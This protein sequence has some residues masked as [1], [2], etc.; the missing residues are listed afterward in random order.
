MAGAIG[1]TVGVTLALKSP[2]VIELP[3]TVNAFVSTAAGWLVML[4]FAP[5][6]LMRQEAEKNREMLRLAARV[7]RLATHGRRQDE[8]LNEIVLER[9]D[10]IGLLSRSIRSAIIAAEADRRHSDRLRRTMSHEIERETRRA[11]KRL[12]YEAETDPLTGLGNRRRLEEVLADWH[13]RENRRA[14]PVLAAVAIDMDHFKAVNDTLGHDVGD[15]CLQ[16]L[17]GVLRSTVREDDCPVRLGGDE[18]IVLM[19]NRDAGDAAAVAKRIA[20]LFGQM[21]WTSDRVPRPTL[22]IGV[23]SMTS[24]EAVE[25]DELLKRA[26][27]SLYKAKEAGRNRMHVEGGRRFVA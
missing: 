9:A 26:D 17:G 12:R 16:F 20:A 22:S 4:V 21:P 18:F 3:S 23:A 7:E 1:I 2:V 25:P 13:A 11:T 15:E 24:R 5:W 19:P 10:E 6:H 14:N 8:S 27:A